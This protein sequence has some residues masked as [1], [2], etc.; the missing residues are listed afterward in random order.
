MSTAP[1]V[2]WSAAVHTR[3]LLSVGLGFVLVLVTAGVALVSQASIR[4]QVM[5]GLERSFQVRD[6]SLQLKL[7]FLR[8]RQS[9]VALMSRIDQIE[10]VELRRLVAD[11]NSAMS[12][13]RARLD[14][15]NR[16]ATDPDALDAIARLGPLLDAYDDAF[17]ALLTASDLPS[18]RLQ[19]AELA[20]GATFERLAVEIDA[21]TRRINDLTAANLRAARQRLEQIE[22]ATFLAL[23]ALSLIAL[24]ALTLTVVNLS[25]RVL[26][27]LTELTSTAHQLAAG[28]L[29]ATAPVHH[30]DELGLLAQRLNAMASQIRELVAT[31][32]ARVKE[33]TTSL[34]RVAETNARL[35]RD[36]Q[37]HARRQQ[38]LFELSAALAEPLDELAIYR[39]LAEHLQDEGLDFRLVAVYSLNEHGDRV[40]Q[41]CLGSHP[42]T[43][44]ARIA[45]GRGL[46]SIAV[47]QGRL[48]YTPDVSQMYDYIPAFATGSE[49]DVP[50]MAEG[51]V[52][53]VLVVQSEQPHSFDEQDLAALQAAANQASN[54][55]TRAKLYESLQHAREAAEAASRAK[56]SFL[57]NMSHEL[58]TP[59]NAI[60]G[61]AELIEEDLSSLGEQ[62]LGADVAKINNSG[63]HLLG[64]INDILDISKI[65]AGKMELHLETFS[66]DTLLDSVVTTVAPLVARGGNRLVVERG[67][68]LGLIHTDQTRLRQV[69]I[70]LLANAAKFTS[71]GVVILRAE[72]LTAD[73]FSFAISDTGIGIDPA[74]HEQIFQ[75]F[76]QADAS[77]TRKYGGSG[78]GLAISRHFCRMMGGD[79]VLMSQPGQGST[80]TVN[81]PAQAPA[82]TPQPAEQPGQALR[83]TA[84]IVEDDQTTRAMLRRVLER[85]GWAVSEST[86]G[87]SGLAE[88]AVIQPAL[89]VLDLTLPDTDGFAFLEALRAMPARANTPTLVVTA[90]DL[91]PTERTRLAGLASHVLHKGRYNQEDLL[92]VVRQLTRS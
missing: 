37:R 41:L 27:P 24:A 33:R 29:H 68:R 81:L 2:S 32:E 73:Q 17:H 51:V 78:L 89:I 13:A 83:R 39:S 74:L 11:H 1:Q 8:A 71:E 48:N 7:A 82:A 87:G 69:L 25:R 77:T 21:I 59:L 50:L 47:Q 20:D 76:S 43:P 34:A 92:R 19:A 3:L 5:T 61:Y 90:T 30:A 26:R 44:P 56:S 72:R 67:Q 86:E 38:A 75:A 9:D 18:R 63:R 80:F 53:A 65:E 52:V 16:V 45:A 40:L 49:V 31:L 23:A 54:A 70:N 64:L 46:S 91:S 12:E 36:E 85:E 28:D 15:L 42:G 35:L 14:A 60:I 6:L 55:L 62:G 66:V 4:P 58:R 57:A 88:V 22:R 79:I 84:L 10:L